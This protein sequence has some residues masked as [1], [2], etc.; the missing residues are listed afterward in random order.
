MT[1]VVG[2]K[3]LEKRGQRR[4]EGKGS[5]Q[6]QNRTQS[7]RRSKRAPAGKRKRAKDRK[8]DGGG[9]ATA[10]SR[11]KGA[12]RTR[13]DARRRQEAEVER[14][15]A[16]A[17]AR[18][19][20][21]RRGSKGRDDR[22]G[23][24]LRDAGGYP[25]RRREN[26]DVEQQTTSRERRRKEE[27]GNR[28]GLERTQGGRRGRTKESERAEKESSGERY[29]KE[30]KTRFPPK[31]RNRE[32]QVG[33]HKHQ[34]ESQ[35]RRMH[36]RGASQARGTLY[37][38]DQTQTRRAG[39]REG[40]HGGAPAWRGAAPGVGPARPSAERCPRGQRPVPSHRVRTAS[41][42]PTARARR[43]ARP[44]LRSATL[45]W[46]P[47]GGRTESPSPR[48]KGHGG[49]TNGGTGR[50]E[51]RDVRRTG[52]REEEGGAGRSVT[53]RRWGGSGGDAAGR[54]ARDE[55]RNTG[56]EG[57]NGDRVQDRVKTGGAGAGERN[58]P[59]RAEQRAE[60]IR[61]KNNK[62][63][64]SSREPPQGETEGKENV[65]VAAE[66]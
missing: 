37:R 54:P 51:R 52:E 50:K 40:A 1:Q 12:R 7:I 41:K 63:K 17:T 34:G 22:R 57:G 8:K 59:K 61:K 66:A 58:K 29:V 65:T 60:A 15:Q 56:G 19:R 45:V 2:A 31:S 43:R 26:V 33:R 24:E 10:L 44:P 53:Q 38:H 9:H 6:T 13:E 5:D 4:Q 21:R 35:E 28:E 47:E 55:A 27:R 25:T 32:Q 39:S 36:E 48:A 3:Q 20:T 64:R 18:K 14:R 46:A 16:V 42:G 49:E 30:S 62:A 23:R 11:R